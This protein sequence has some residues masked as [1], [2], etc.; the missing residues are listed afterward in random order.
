MAKD[1]ALPSRLAS[2]KRHCMEEMA[3]E[4]KLKNEAAVILS[5]YAA[6]TLRTVAH[7]RYL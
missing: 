1:L 2:G 7:V 3:Y 6:R 4:Y 5:S